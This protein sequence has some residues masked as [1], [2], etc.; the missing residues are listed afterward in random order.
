[1]TIHRLPHLKSSGQDF[2]DEIPSEVNRSTERTVYV[3][4]VF[5]FSQMM[6]TSFLHFVQR[7]LN[8]VLSARSCVRAFVSGLKYAKKREG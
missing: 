7:T 6:M 3:V 4:F 5:R 2:M 1:M 8:D